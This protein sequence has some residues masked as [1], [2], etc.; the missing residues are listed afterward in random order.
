MIDRKRTL[1]WP[2]P[3]AVG[4]ASAPPAGRASS[5]FR[6]PAGLALLAAILAVAPADGQPLPPVRSTS[7]AMVDLARDFALR[8]GSAPSAHDATHVRLLLE[9]GAR[10]DPRNAE[11]Q[12]WLFELATLRGET[13]AART[14]LQ[15]LIAIE[16]DNETALARWL[17]IGSQGQTAEDRAS[18]LRA[19]VKNLRGDRMRAIGAMRLAEVA[20][21]QLD[22]NAAREALR[23][24]AALRP[25]SPQVA[26]M[27]WQLAPA[28]ADAATRFAMAL[29]AFE[30]NPT[31]PHFAWAVGVMLDDSGFHD[32]A[33]TYF[34]HALALAPELSGPS[35]RL[36]LAENA[37]KRGDFRETERLVRAVASGGDA[38]DLWMFAHWL[39]TKQG[40]RREA[41]TVRRALAGRFST[42]AAPDAS[43]GLIAQAAW[44]YCEIE[45][46]PE[47]ALTLAQRAVALAPEDV[48]AQRALGWGQALSGDVE[49]ARQTLA[50]IADRDAWAA[51][52]LAQ[53]QRESGDAPAA[54]QTLADLKTPPL[55]GPAHEALLALDADRFKPTPGRI[56]HPEM[57]ALLD[58]IDPR[59]FP[60]ALRPADLVTARVDL[61]DRDPDIAQPWRATFTLTNAAP[62]EAPLGPD[63]VIN[64]TFLLSFS[65]SGEKAREYEHVL[66]VTYDKT[67]TIAPG[68]TVSVTTT[69]DVGAHAR[70]CA[71]T[72]QQIQHV[73][74]TAL[75]DPAQ[76]AEGAWLGHK[77]P[78]LRFTRTPAPVGAEAWAARFASLRGVDLI[79]QI[80]A[81]EEIARL[82]GESQRAA[83]GKLGYATTPVPSEA[84]EQALL[85]ALRHG[86]WELRARTLLAMRYAGLTAPLAAEVERALSDSHWLPRMLALRLLARQGPAFGE[87]AARVAQEDAD[88][89]VRGFA[90]MIVETLSR[91]ENAD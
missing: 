71:L 16:P 15:A 79:A 65:L 67:Q 48:I 91:A 21:E 36:V 83:R 39:L 50:A 14:A 40:L 12:R 9:A 26:A 81:V 45:P 1:C 5:R 19:E 70:A 82:L 30:R 85:L 87:V 54:E 63:G 46:N 29:A 10:L 64:P 24:A 18:W 23:A 69:I 84:A 34:S 68:E 61:D 2:G 11:A 86:D 33:H 20:M 52:K 17:E 76:D 51:V 57:A 42:A 37:L 58:K 59:I 62:Y 31:R 78:L 72:P 77:V 22:L 47:V 38:P 90:A 55:A 49:S 35:E 13:D 32:E 43:A 56:R 44:F 28:D 89:L 74:L 3:R 80:R 27:Q 88:A 73:T 75:L 41:D 60:A 53:L 4:H 25:Q 66:S 8:R 7:E 6:A